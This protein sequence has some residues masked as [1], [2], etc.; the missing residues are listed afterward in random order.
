MDELNKNVFSFNN[1]E[2]ISSNKYNKHSTHSNKIM[3]V[4]DIMYTLISYTTKNNISS[5]RNNEHIDQ[6]DQLQVNS[7][8]VLCL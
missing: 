3:T 5:N 8:C 2:K 4:I 7:L 6:R 1:D